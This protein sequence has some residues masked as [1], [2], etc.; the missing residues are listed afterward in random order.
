MRITFEQI[1]EVRK[2]DQKKFAE[3]IANNFSSR[4]ILTNE[5][6]FIHPVEKN[7]ESFNLVKYLFLTEP[8]FDKIISIINEKHQERITKMEKE[9]LDR[10]NRALLNTKYLSMSSDREIATVAIMAFDGK[11]IDDQIFTKAC[12]ELYHQK[13]NMGPLW[14]SY[15]WKG[16]VELDQIMGFLNKKAQT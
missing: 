10:Y 4:D 1:N 6:S 12:N 8:E 5:L 11:E 15:L 16:Y 13:K 7:G 14:K 9:A 3:I 2:N